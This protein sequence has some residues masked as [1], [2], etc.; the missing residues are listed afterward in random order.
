LSTTPCSVNGESGRKELEILADKERAK[1]GNKLVEVM[2]IVMNQRV[3]KPPLSYSQ[4]KSKHTARDRSLLPREL[5]PK[6]IKMRY[7]SFFHNGHKLTFKR[8]ARNWDL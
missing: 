4:D 7:E 3:D 5:G 6:R 8:S 1:T 2:K